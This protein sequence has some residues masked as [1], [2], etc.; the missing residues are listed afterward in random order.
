MVVTVDPITFQV[1][2][3]ALTGIVREM[4][5]LLFRT[6]YSTAIRESQDASCAILDIDGNLVAQYRSLYMHMGIFPVCIEALTRSYPREVMEPGD[7]FILNHPYQGGSTHVSDMAVI[8][9]VFYKNKLVAFC[10]S[11]AHKTDIGGAIPGSASGQ[12]TEIYQEGLLLPPVKYVSRGVT[13]REV[14]AVLR[15]N[16]RTPHVLT[17]DIRGQIGVCR[18]GEDRVGRMMD[19][20][21]AD[22]IL[23]AFQ[24]LMARTERRVRAGISAWP[25]GRVE[26][27]G[28]LDA[29]GIV[30][31]RPVKLH[32][33][34]TK[35]GES[36]VFDFSASDSQ[37][38]GPLN[39][40][41]STVVSTCYFGLIAIIDPTI[42]NN[43][44]L[45]RSM[46]ARF[47]PHSV[48]N[49]DPPGPVSCYSTTS[50]KLLYLVVVA[51]RRLAGQRPIA[52][53]G[54]G[55]A[56]TIGGRSIFTGQPYIQY[57][58]LGGG[59]GAVEG[60]DGAGGSHGIRGVPGQ[61]REVP[62]E[63]LETEFACRLLHYE[64][65]IDSGGPGK[66]RGGPGT[67]K[68][69]LILDKEA[70][71]GLRSNGFI[72]PAD[73]DGGG[74]PGRPTAATLNRGTPQER[75]LPCR[76]AD[77]RLKPGD[78]LRVET[79]GGG[80]VGDPR[81]RDREKVVEDVEN[82]FVSPQQA[83]EVYGLKEAPGKPVRME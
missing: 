7:A 16:S 39:L 33:A 30:L 34:V 35:K 36:L 43:G 45:A 50:G 75:R 42:P 47:A 61:I 24:E 13:S 27:E 8:T 41:P 49:P 29:D 23:W 82:G 52:D 22:T 2:S 79:G 11:M 15:A 78:V 66:F 37:T 70:R 81:Q 77:V 21:S 38:L 20:Y 46:E 69:Y 80:G 6:G 3:T 54:T 1:I 9:P 12:S 4:Q 68:E 19:K 63:I 62:I 72:F 83:R 55:G 31:T 28:F 10:T 65:A 59:K 18:I 25:D 26:V 58:L 56:L 57:E 64:M 5:L 76:I 71:M 40:K 17:G 32:V 48:L 73:G 67:I 14:D 44:G 53:S 60:D 74:M 51:L